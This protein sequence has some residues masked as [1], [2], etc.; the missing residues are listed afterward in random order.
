MS[1]DPYQNTTTPPKEPYQDFHRGPD[2]GTG[3]SFLVGA[4]ILLA[5]AGFI[6]YYANSDNSNVATNDMRPPITQPNTTGSGTPPET[7]GSGN[8]TQQQPARPA[9]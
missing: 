8:T 3:T 7:T 9:K 6:Y 2:G 5:L 4:L 1:Y